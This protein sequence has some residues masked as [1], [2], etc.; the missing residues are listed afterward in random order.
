[1]GR[2]ILFVTT[3]GAS[4]GS[5]TPFIHTPWVVGCWPVSIVERDGMHTTDCG[6]ARSYRTPAA[7][8]PSTTGV[9]ASV[10]PLHPRVS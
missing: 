3:D 2:K 7:A 10:P 9:R 5:G 4:T 6:I 1:M 8:R